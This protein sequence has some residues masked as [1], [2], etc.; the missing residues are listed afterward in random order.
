MLTGKPALDKMI[1][2]LTLLSSLGVVGLFVY[3]EIVFKKPLP[4]DQIEKQ[5]LLKNRSTILNTESYNIEKLTANLQS[6][7]NRLRYVDIKAHLLPFK[8]IFVKKL[9][10]NKAA[11]H[12]IIFDVSSKSTFEELSSVSGKILYES[13]I[14]DR[15]ND[16]FGKPIVKEIQFS[17]FVVQ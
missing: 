11:I 16:F 8:P 6:P 15:I 2:V 17:H 10:E 9:E 4:S 13:R 5:E 3:T 12:D 14:K 7:S 1:I